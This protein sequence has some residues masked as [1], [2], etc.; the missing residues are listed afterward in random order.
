MVGLRQ[1]SGRA[2]AN[3]DR[4]GDVIQLGK[5]QFA[6]PVEEAGFRN[7]RVLDEQGQRHRSLEECVEMVRAGKLRRDW[8]GDLFAQ[9]AAV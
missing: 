1:S 9:R 4:V 2:D 6:Q 7:I 8:V 3:G 5:R